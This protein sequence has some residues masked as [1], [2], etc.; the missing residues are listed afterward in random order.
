MAGKIRIE[1]FNG[2]STI[3]VSGVKGKACTDITKAVEEALGKVEKR[4]YTTDYK[5]KEL[6]Q[7]H[8]VN[9]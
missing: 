9:Q 8:R 7:V 6:D 1:F 2:K 3:S 5:E 4:E